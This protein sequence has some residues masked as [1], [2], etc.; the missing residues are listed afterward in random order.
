M[1]DGDELSHGRTYRDPIRP[2]DSAT[3]AGKREACR[4]RGQVILAPGLIP[5]LREILD[6]GVP[7][8]VACGFA[9]ALAQTLARVPAIELL[10]RLESLGEKL[11][12]DVRKP[13]PPV[14]K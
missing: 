6:W 1:T 4:G 11:E 2:S 9:E 12:V 14:G 3:A 7:A 8:K 10:N 5:Y 13:R